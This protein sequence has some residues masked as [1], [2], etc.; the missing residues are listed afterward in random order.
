M[1]VKEGNL[2]APKRAAIDWKDPD[3]YDEESLQNEMER[4][5]EACHGCR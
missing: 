1:E 3:Y 5:F 4:V 2:Q